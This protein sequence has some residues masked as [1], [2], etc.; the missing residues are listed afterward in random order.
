MRCLKQL[1]RVLAVAILFTACACVF[2]QDGQERSERYGTVNF[3]VS[4]NGEAQQRFN[5]AVTMLHSFFFP[6]TIKA[7]NNVLEADPECAMAYWGI[8]ISQRPNP[9]V[10]PWDNA[11]LQRGVDAIAKGKTLARTP[12][13]KGWLEAMELFFKDY[14][15]IDQPTRARRYANAMEQVYVKYPEDTEAGVFYA[16]A[17]NETADHHDKTYAQQLK[18]A[19]I[20][21]K[22]GAQQPD[23]PGITHYI[24]HSYDFEPLAQRGI[25]AADKYAKIA[26]SAPH[27]L[28]MPSHIYSMIGSWEQSIASNKESL[29]AAKAYA[30]K[31]FPG[32]SDPSEAHVYDFME[33]AYLQLGQDQQAKAV[34]DAVK[35]I[36][37][38]AFV[39]PTVDIGVAATQARYVL[40]RG[41]WAEAAALEPRKS[42]FPYAEAVGIFARAVGSARTKNFDQARRAI[43]EL[44]AREEANVKAKL[45][46]WGEQTAILVKAASAWLSWADGKNA[47]AQ[48]LMREAADL[49]DSS[50]KDVAME[51][52]LFPARE[53]LGYLLLELKEP[54]MAL[55]E[56]ETAN[57]QT[58]QR[59]R[60]YYG[61]ARAAQLAGDRDKATMYFQKLAALTKNADTDRQEIREAKAFLGSARTSATDAGR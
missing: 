24:I 47:E 25:P 8:A 44:R 9:L 53:Q 36:Q 27:A 32:A 6:E 38:F 30:A 5:R 40:E 34:V 12:R 58:P 4:C 54:Q 55:T 22:I 52:R 49:E 61:A 29:A 48:K 28:H 21:E 13:E 11:T 14:Q 33:Y 50:A 15:T 41:A 7:F 39:R 2:A 17:L 46:Y 3:P 19:A 43:E 57:K 60:G 37:K 23:H 31:Y 59:L 18:A 20:L 51:N 42:Q 16:L 56:F 26:P 35:A 45:P 10:G 1:S